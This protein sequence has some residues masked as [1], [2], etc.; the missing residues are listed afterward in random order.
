[1]TVILEDDGRGFEPEQVFAA[2][3]SSS[4][5]G[6]RGMRE[7]VAL[8]GGSFHVESE[9]GAG[10]TVFVRIPVGDDRP[11]LPPAEPAS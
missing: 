10:T 5:L 1:V 3:G 11:A 8:L 4:R 2:S 6:L 7:R 9:H